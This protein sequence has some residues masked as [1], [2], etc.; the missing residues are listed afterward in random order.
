MGL[1]NLPYVI[2]QIIS[3]KLSEIHTCLPGKIVKYEYKTQKAQV[4]PLIKKQYLDEKEET[5]PIIVN[6]PVVWPRASKCSLTFPLLKDDYVML[7]FSERAMEIFLS[8]GD[9]QLPGDTRQFHLSDCIAIPGL[10]PFCEDSLATNNTDCLWV[11]D[12][13]SIRLKGGVDENGEPL[14]DAGTIVITGSKDLNIVIEQNTDITSGTDDTNTFEHTSTGDTTY[15]YG[16]KSTNTLT[17]NVTG[18]NAITISGDHSLD[19]TGSSDITINGACDLTVNGKSTVT[20]NDDVKID[21][22]GKLDA[23]ASGNASVTAAQITL[24]G[25]VIINGSLNVTST[26]TATGDVIGNGISLD[27]HVHSGV[28][29]GGSNTGGP[30]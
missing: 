7:L 12:E 18:D 15:N 30:V 2:E 26:I 24:N 25:P 5:L 14:E 8:D 27:S 1:Q 16:S 13:T 3:R 28:A 10:Y 17:I 21:V 11:Y 19:I 9:I 20:A 23:T 29:T 22:T 4:Q 6:V